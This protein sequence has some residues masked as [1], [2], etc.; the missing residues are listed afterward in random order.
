[1]QI[2]SEDKLLISR[3][4]D[5]LRIAESRYTT[6][7]LGFLN[8]RERILIEKT[9]RGDMDMT[10]VFDGGYSD[11]ERTLF[12][13]YPEYFVPD[14]NEYICLLEITGRDINSLSHRDFL[15]SLMGLGIVRENIGDILVLENH[16]LVFVKPDI[17][18][19]IIQNLTKIGRCGISVSKV[20]TETVVIPQRP[21]KDING[22]VSAL[23]LDSVASVGA[24]ISRT[25]AVDL[26]KA[27]LVTVNWEITDN[28][29]LTIKEGDILSIR[30]FGRMKLSKIGG[31]T[32]KNRY[33]ITVS[34]YI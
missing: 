8:P 30:G 7:T 33:F 29:S 17:A 6:K 4:E 32:R 18:D 31:L 19:Y 5:T 27:G 12:V 25:K 9:V 24:G 3:A 16:T 14:R 10:A 26:I 1:M 2:S 34:R 28:I 15:G 21:V 20:D 22:T 23:R 13:C 11:A